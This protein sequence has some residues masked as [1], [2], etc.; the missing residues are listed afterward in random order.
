[1]YCSLRSL[2]SLREEPN[3]KKSALTQ[4][5]PLVSLFYMRLSFCGSSP[6]RAR[7]CLGALAIIHACGVLASRLTLSYC[8]RL[9]ASL[10]GFTVLYSCFAGLSPTPSKCS[11]RVLRFPRL[12]LSCG[13]F[14]RGFPTPGPR[15][16]RGTRGYFSLSPPPQNTLISGGG[17]KT[18]YSLYSVRLFPL[19]SCPLRGLWGVFVRLPLPP[20]ARTA[21]LSVFLIP[22]SALDDSSFFR[23]AFWSLY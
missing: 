14:G 2:R 8:A 4:R 10:I 9:A 23:S 19:R 1:M 3:K 17:S 12:A 20:R 16:A 13:L 15:W 22:F 11:A 21:S 6:C 7:F 5:W 18:Q